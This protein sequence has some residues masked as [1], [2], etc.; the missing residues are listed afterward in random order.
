MRPPHSASSCASE[1]NRIAWKPGG[2]PG[3]CPELQRTV[4]APPYAAVIGR[5][6][7]G[8]PCPAED[9]AATIVGSITKS[10]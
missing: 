1:S 2:T 4:F 3:H 6:A 7:E 5:T 9:K 10:S 8:H